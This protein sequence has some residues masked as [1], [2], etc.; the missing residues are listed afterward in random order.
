[1]IRL[2]RNAYKSV[3]SGLK[4]HTI[5][6]RLLK[7]RDNYEARYGELSKV[8]V[9]YRD[10]NC[11]K[12]EKEALEVLQLA[13]WF[14][15]TV[16]KLFYDYKHFKLHEKPILSSMIR[17]YVLPS[18]AA[19]MLGVL[20]AEIAYRKQLKEEYLGKLSSF[21]IPGGIHFRLK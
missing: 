21:S 15:T 5:N 2:V 6:Q 10:S 17:G 7:S 16:D 19:A 8:V 18:A 1:M 11:P 13:K 4:Y 14:R 12:K 3:A 9:Y 20:V